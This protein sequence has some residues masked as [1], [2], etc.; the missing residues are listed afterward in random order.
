MSRYLGRRSLEKI[1]LQFI[2]HN[3]RVPPLLHFRLGT[4]LYKEKNFTAA[5]EHFLAAINGRSTEF[6]W[7]VRLGLAI[8]KQHDRIDDAIS[9]YSKAIQK[10]P[11]AAQ[12]HYRLARCLTRKRQWTQAESESRRAITLEAENPL[13][14]DVLAL[15]LRRQ[16]KYF[17]EIEILKES[18]PFCSDAANWNFRIGES[19][20]LVKS[21]ADAAKFFKKAVELD[22]NNPVWRYRCGYAMQLANKKEE[23]KHFYSSAIELALSQNPKAPCGVFGVAV[24]HQQRGLWNQA[25]STYA[26][27]LK[28]NPSPELY[29]RSGKALERCY[30]WKDAIV[31]Y[32]HALRL[33]SDFPECRYA[34]GF[35]LERTGD[36]CSAAKAYLDAAVSAPLHQPYWYYRAGYALSKLEKYTDACN[37]FLQTDLCLILNLTHCHLQ[38]VAFRPETVISLTVSDLSR[39]QTLPLY[40]ASDY[41]LLGNQ[42]ETQGKWT[43]AVKQYSEAIDRKEEHEPSWYYRLGYCLTMASKHKEACTAF[44]EMRIIKDAHGA[45]IK[46]YTNA[47]LTKEAADYAAYY[48]ELAIKERTILYECFHG[49]GMSCNPLAIYRYVISSPEFEGWKHVWVVNDK[50]K[51]PEQYRFRND[52]IFVSRGS[53]LY[54]RYL[55][56]VSVLINNNSFPPYFMRKPGQTYLNTWHGTPIKTLAKDLK[57]GFQEHKNVS[58]NFYHCTHIISPNSHT[59]NVLL[60]GHDIAETFTGIFAETGYP[61]VDITLCTEETQADALRQKLKIRTDRKTVLYAPT[62]RGS[63][64][65][66]SSLETDR[67]LET[68]TALNQLDANVLFRGHHKTEHELS[69]LN[70]DDM[71]V[72]SDI[73]TNELL[74]IVDV[75]ITDYSSIAIDYL[76]TGRPIVYYVYDLEQYNAERGLYFPLDRLPGKQCQ[77][78]DELVVNTESALTST[79]TDPAIDSIATQIF[80]PHDDGQATKR[81]VDLIFNGKTDGIHVIPNQKRH[82]LLFYAGAMIPNG[83]TN[84]FINLVSNIDQTKYAVT[85]VIDPN[86]VGPYP[87]RLEQLN[88]LPTGIQILA[89]VGNAVQTL[90]EKWIL[91]SFSVP[92]QFLSPE[93][94]KIYENAFSREFKRCFGN[95]S[96]DT[97][98]VFDGYNRNWLSTFACAPV[99]PRTFKIVYLHSDMLNEQKTRFPN[100]EYNF[101]LY[102]HFHKLVSVS[103]STSKINQKNL[104]EVLS[105]GLPETI[106]TSCRNAFNA[107][108]ILERRKEKTLSASDLSLFRR[109]GPKFVTLGRLSPEKGHDRLITAFANVLAEK[110]NAQLFIIG[111]GPMECDLQRLIDKHHLRSSVHLMGSHFNPFPLV[112]QG[113]CF[114]LASRY[115]GQGLVLLEAM[116]LGLCIIC[117]DFPAAHDLLD[118]T[119]GLIVENSENGLFTGMQKFIHGEL[120]PVAFDHDGYLESALSDFYHL[121]NPPRDY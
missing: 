35:S 17:Q 48:D 65:A 119:S 31:Q 27:M 114:V 33:K 104:N 38:K 28:E 95:M 68:L 108:D 113:D 62:Y 81:V 19:C 37:A 109:N 105:L 71:L 1:R 103:P 20:E 99:S 57:T 94:M 60:H 91:A 86:S 52:T 50:E 90:E 92:N 15:S 75:L 120:S 84:S 45:P 4:T 22:P 23:A 49:A 58:R 26:D 80:C 88:R 74:A 110:R 97:L 69:N 18:L 98:I 76:K 39:K 116:S 32:Q 102:R 53:T 85:L 30:R 2:S 117:T 34:L 63:S 54:L 7:H 56:E 106:F 21:Y 43:E 100:L 13:M 118:G 47:S 67:I 12:L 101:K 10:F 115:E 121:V 44:L 96:V 8:E 6:R 46:A 42:L 89:T 79:Q 14:Y 66:K 16:N 61:R 82:S 93:K 55:C 64:L 111:D 107:S 25:A 36:Y 77:S 73:D 40:D 3:Y 78:L 59:T 112:S 87:D 29:F 24:F 9:V 51:I 83:I 41:F 72:P 11:E 70:L 5:E